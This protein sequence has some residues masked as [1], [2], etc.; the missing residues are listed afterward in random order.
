MKRGWWHYVPHFLLAVAA[1][2]LLYRLRLVLAPFVIAYLLAAGLDPVVVHMEGH[3]WRRGRAVLYIYAIF[4]LLFT[5]CLVTLLPVAVAQVGEL[6]SEVPG[7]VEKAPLLFESVRERLGSVEVPQDYRDA[8]TKHAGDIANS[9]A[10][11]VAAWAQG[12]IGSVG[13]LLWL[14]LIPVA[15]FFLLNDIRRVR[16]NLLLLVP[17]RQRTAAQAMAHDVASVFVSYLRGLAIVA[18]LYGLF[19][20]VT[21]LA[22]GMPYA[23]AIGIMG[24][25]LY[26]VPY[27]GPIVTTIAILVVGA[28]TEGWGVGLAAAGL[29]LVLNQVFDLGLF[30]RIAGKSVDL[31]PVSC[32]IA[33]LIGAELFGL[34]GMLLAYPA[35]GAVKIIVVRLMPHLRPQSQGLAEEARSETPPKAEPAR[36]RAK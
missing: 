1:L 33:L 35:A 17:A 15:T 24:G 23:V 6:A 34:P 16:A 26:P 31:H 9:V 13:F 10:K 5:I 21:L 20:L 32:M 7:Y 27:L 3:G 12:I 2:L 28:V 14:V 18:V 8:V 25:V 29:S 11:R 22:L 19:L 4:L 36:K 30:P